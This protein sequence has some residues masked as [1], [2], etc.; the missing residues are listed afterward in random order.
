M[1]GGCA[2]PC[3]CSVDATGQYLLVAHYTGGSVAMTPLASDG[4]DEEASHLVEHEGSGPNAERQASAHPH[5]IR[6]GPA[7]RFADVPDL[8]TD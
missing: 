2:D 8:G 4:A 1:T 5:S 6:P 3:Y 7:N